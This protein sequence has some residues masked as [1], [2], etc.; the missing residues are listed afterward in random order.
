MKQTISEFGLIVREGKMLRSDTCAEYHS[1]PREIVMLPGWSVSTLVHEAVHAGF[2]HARFLSLVGECQEEVICEVAG[3]IAEHFL[4][5]TGTD[6][7][8]RGKK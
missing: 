1:S 7:F 6:R 8:R 5:R 2:D 3:K 4:A